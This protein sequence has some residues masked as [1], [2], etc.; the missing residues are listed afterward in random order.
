MTAILTPADALRG[1]PPNA[2]MSMSA[3]LS[4]F[5]LNRPPRS[6]VGT[7]SSSE[8]RRVGDNPARRNRYP[9]C[10]PLV[11]ARRKRAL[12]ENRRNYVAVSPLSFKGE[13]PGLSRRAGGRTLLR[14]VNQD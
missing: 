8:Y 3:G 7:G 2:P 14:T 9:C 4:V 11:S 6:C 12:S 13:D 1:S 10:E 5:V